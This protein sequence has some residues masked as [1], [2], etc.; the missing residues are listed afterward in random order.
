[1]AQVSVQYITSAPTQLPATGGS[2]INIGSVPIMVAPTKNKSD[3]NAVSIGPAGTLPW[4]NTWACWSWVT[5]AANG[6][7]YTV[8]AQL[9]YAP[10]TGGVNGA[11]TKFAGKVQSSAPANLIATGELI[12]V[13]G[14]WIATFESG[15]TLPSWLTTSDGK[16]L[17]ATGYSGEYAHFVFPDN[18]PLLIPDGTIIINN[19]SGNSVSAG[20]YYQ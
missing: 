10:G 6:Q 14:F 17:L 2:I 1:V 8:D 18:S 16:F 13:L 7:A 12:T 19:T 20:V 3:P 11:V 15:G 9:S 5:G 4:S